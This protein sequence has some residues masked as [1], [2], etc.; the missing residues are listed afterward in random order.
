VGRYDFDDDIYDG[1]CCVDTV[2]DDNDSGV[3]LR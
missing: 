2:D 3:Y 1:G